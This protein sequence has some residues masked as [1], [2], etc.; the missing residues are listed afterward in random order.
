MDIYEIMTFEEMVQIYNRNQLSLGISQKC[1][2]SYLMKTK[3]P[4]VSKSM[5]CIMLS[6]VQLGHGLLK[7]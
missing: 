2:I 4:D 7:H 6:T 5:F 3:S 1:L